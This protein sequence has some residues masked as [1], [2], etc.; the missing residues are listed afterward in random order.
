MPDVGGA[1]QSSLLLQYLGFWVRGLPVEMGRRVGFSPCNP[2]KL[3]RR[4]TTVCSTAPEPWGG[5]RPPANPWGE[6]VAGTVPGQSPK[7]L[8]Q[9]GLV[10]GALGQEAGSQGLRLFLAGTRAPCSLL[11]RPFPNLFM[12][13]MLYPRQL[14][15]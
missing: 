1:P 14:H 6:E 7:A 15:P 13:E 4:A 3:Q 5:T 2:S 12:L 8:G 9:R 10:A 11:L